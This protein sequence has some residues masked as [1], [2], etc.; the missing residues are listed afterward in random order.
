MNGENSPGIIAQAMLILIRAYQLTLSSLVGRYCRHLPTCSQYAA[1]A[2]SRHGAWAG[3][4]LAFFRVLRCHPWG[5]EGFDPVP[6]RID[7]LSL[8]IGVYRRAGRR[9]A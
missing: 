7:R 3:F 9:N 2:I 5:S 4:W 1:D 6:E 8:N